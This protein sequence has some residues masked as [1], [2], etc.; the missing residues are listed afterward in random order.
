MDFWSPIQLA[1]RIYANGGYYGGIYGFT[2][3][4]SSQL[5]FVA[6]DQYDSW[7]PAYYQGAIY[8]FIDGNVRCQDMNN[9]TTN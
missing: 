8:S 3:A 1:N 6:L 9:G 7:S 2:T 5:F 4:P